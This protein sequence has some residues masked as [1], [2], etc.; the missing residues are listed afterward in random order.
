MPYQKLNISGYKFG[1]DGYLYDNLQ[2][3]KNKAIKHNWDSFG[4]ITGREGAGKSTLTSQQGILLNPKMTLKNWSWTPEQFEKVIEESPPE[5]SIIWDEAITGANAASW[6]SSI[7]Q[8]VIRLLTQI[9]KKRLKI[10]ICFPYLNLLNKYFVSRCMFS[11]WVYAR[12]FSDRGYARFYNQKETEYAY[13]LI[14]E[15]FRLRPFEGMKKAPYSFS[16]NY[17]DVLCVPEDE[18][19]KLKDEGRK[20]AENQG[21]DK[22]KIHAINMI[23]Y[24]KESAKNKHKIGVADLAKNLG[25]T[26]QYLYR[27]VKSLDN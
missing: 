26:E 11:I 2:L 1:M 23:K 14:K 20:A 27:L 19:E 18:Y 4:I 21:G 5:S 10:L 6:A 24:V 15:K 12:S 9:R 22:W 13:G 16:F 7:S 8:S 3:I 25:M 17:P